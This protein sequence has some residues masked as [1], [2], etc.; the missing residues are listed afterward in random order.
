MNANAKFFRFSAVLNL[1]LGAIGF[2]ILWGIRALT[3]NNI[4]GIVICSVVFLAIA[5]F[6]NIYIVKRSKLKIP[7]FI[8]G[9]A[10]NAIVVAVP[11]ILMMVL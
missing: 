6:V 1:I 10:V 11:T 2:L 5:L 7:Y 9:T 8:F 4:I 3:A